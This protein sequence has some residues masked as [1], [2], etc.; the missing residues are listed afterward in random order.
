MHWV[1]NQER[2]SPLFEP[3]RGSPARLSAG[4]SVLAWIVALGL[5]GFLLLVSIEIAIWFVPR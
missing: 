5:I 4:K 1:P 2:C 3:H